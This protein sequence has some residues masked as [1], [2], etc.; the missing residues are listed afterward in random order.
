MMWSEKPQVSFD[1]IITP[2]FIFFLAG[3]LNVHTMLEPGEYW[4]GLGL[5]TAYWN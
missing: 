1:L 5:V 4:D 3:T 2:L